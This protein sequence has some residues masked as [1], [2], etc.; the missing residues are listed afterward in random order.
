MVRRQQP[1]SI[2]PV[3]TFEITTKN[4]LSSA[5]SKFGM[6]VI[7]RKC[8]LSYSGYLPRGSNDSVYV[9]AAEKFRAK[10]VIGE[11]VRRGHWKVRVFK[12]NLAD[13]VQ[14][15]QRPRTFRVILK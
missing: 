8:K 12:F 5:M 11:N 9:Y 13:I 6:F 15:E 10:F 2:K 3:S 1:P 14:I 7:G 4:E